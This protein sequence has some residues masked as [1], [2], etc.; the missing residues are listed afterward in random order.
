[1]EVFNRKNY[2]LVRKFEEKCGTGKPF[3]L[4][5][6]ILRSDIEKFVGMLTL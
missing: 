5:P 1:M 6:D 3:D 2:G 4:W